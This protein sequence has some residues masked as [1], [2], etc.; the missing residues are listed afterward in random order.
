M[1]G[2]KSFIVPDCPLRHLTGPPGTRPSAGHHRQTSR[3]R[4]GVTL[5][6]YLLMQFSSN[7]IEQSARYDHHIFFLFLPSILTIFAGFDGQW[8]GRP[9]M[10]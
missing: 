6:K 7:G 9:L 2:L 5:K 8:E 1:L 10:N 3:I 4:E